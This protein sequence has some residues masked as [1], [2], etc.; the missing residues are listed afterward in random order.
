MKNIFF[1]IILFFT[2]VALPSCLDSDNPYEKYADWRKQNDE[3]INSRLYEKNPDGSMKYM[4]IVPAWAPNV[5]VLMQWHNDTSL[6]RKNLSP[7]DNSRISV[8]YEGMLIDSTKFDSSYSRTDSSY[9][10]MPKNNIMGWRAALPYMHVGDSVTML[11]ASGAAYGSY[12]TSV[13]KPY[14]T[15]IFNV[16]LREIIDFETP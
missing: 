13:I 1:A 16:K 3:Y 10:T 7:L 9:V 6:T 2:L 11:I 15:L 14:S 4:R 5:L 8:K 12:G